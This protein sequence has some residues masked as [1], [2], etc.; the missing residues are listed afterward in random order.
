MKT[1]YMENPFQIPNYPIVKWVEYF[2]GV[3]GSYVKTKLELEASK[4]QQ[5]FE[6]SLA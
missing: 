1:I 2:D 5:A 4:H 6:A 3:V